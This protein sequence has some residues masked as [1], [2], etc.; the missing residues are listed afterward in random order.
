[1]PELAR[2]DTEEAA[3]EMVDAE[4]IMVDDNVVDDEDDA[5]GGVEVVDNTGDVEVEV[6]SDVVTIRTGLLETGAVVSIGVVVV[7]TSIASLVTTAEF[8][9]ETAETGVVV[10]P[11]T[12][13]PPT[14]VASTTSLSPAVT[15]TVC[16]TSTVD[17]TTSQ[18]VT[19]TRSRLSS[20]AALASKVRREPRAKNLD[21]CMIG[22]R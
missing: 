3:E 22:I 17:V 14:E 6:D 4:D 21:R 9:T 11:A 10:D 19:T 2:P 13:T 16:T 1:M 15:Q 8:K 7:L 5:E 12:S 18:V 20:G